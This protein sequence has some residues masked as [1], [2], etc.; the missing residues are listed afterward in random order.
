MM[1]LRGSK[2]VAMAALAGGGVALVVLTT[3]V[4]LVEMLIT[5]A[6]ISEMLPA[7]APPLSLLARLL[8]AAFAGVMAI[9]ITWTVTGKTKQRALVDSRAKGDRKMGFALSKLTALARGRS[10]FDGAAHPVPAVRRADA[11]PDAPAR[12]PIFASRDFDGLDIFTTPAPEARRMTQPEAIEPMVAVELE[13][14][15]VMPAVGLDMP[16]APEPLAEA[17]LPPVPVFAGPGFTPS[18]VTLSE[19]EDL[20]GH[21]PAPLA[22]ATPAEPTDPRPITSLSITEL[23]ARL[24]R[25]LTQRGAPSIPRVIADMP[26]ADPVPVSPMVEPDVDE[27]LRAALGTL[28]TLAARAG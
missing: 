12:A 2:D 15:I 8:I 26:V 4:G 6:G 24:E 28:R 1:G 22:Q 17:E 9:G 20:S 14:N 18:F 23:T 25:G 21:A 16:R 3:P 10:A 7:A 19:Q 11:H 27:A 5:S 13:R